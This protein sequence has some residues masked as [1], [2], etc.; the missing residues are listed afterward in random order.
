MT[1]LAL[2]ILISLEELP[3]NDFIKNNDHVRMGKNPPNQI[4]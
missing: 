1:P 3:Q 4:G 2:F